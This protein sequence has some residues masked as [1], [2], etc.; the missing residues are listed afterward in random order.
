MGDHFLSTTHA[1]TH[2]LISVSTK[3]KQYCGRPLFFYLE[4]GGP[5]NLTAM[6]HP[7]IDRQ[8][9]FFVFLA[10]LD[11]QSTQAN[12]IDHYCVMLVLNVEN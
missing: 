10:T 6:R 2:A 3:S 12:S 11:H 9:N 5:A 4:A 1:S 7:M 8:A